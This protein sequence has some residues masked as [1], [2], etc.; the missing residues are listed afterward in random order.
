VPRA[1]TGPRGAPRPSA[2]AGRGRGP[3]PRPAPTPANRAAPQKSLAEQL[4]EASSNLKKPSG[5]NKA[6]AAPGG[7]AQKTLAEQLQEQL[8]KME[9]RKKAKQA[10]ALGA[11]S[12]LKEPAK[13]PEEDKQEEGNTAWDL[14]RKLKARMNAL[15]GKGGKKSKVVET[16]KSNFKKSQHL[17]DSDE[18]PDEFDPQDSDYD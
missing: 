10:A 17:A 7:G 3:A 4:A 14:S 6:K 9:E 16:R 1:P 8:A 12:A 18:T 13:E 2:P 11:K 15:H 5:I